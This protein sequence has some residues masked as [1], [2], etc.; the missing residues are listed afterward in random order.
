MKDKEKAVKPHPLAPEPGEPVITESLVPVPVLGKM[1]RNI[2]LALFTLVKVSWSKDLPEGYTLKGNLN[3]PGD[4][5]GYVCL[6]VCG[7][8]KYAWKLV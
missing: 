2:Y 4:P 8:V 1:I 5:P 7:V 6:D 3:V